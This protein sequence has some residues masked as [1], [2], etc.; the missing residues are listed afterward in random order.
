MS[1]LEHL[2]SAF[3]LAP[4]NYAMMYTEKDALPVDFALSRYG[5]CAHSTHEMA[6]ASAA[7]SALTAPRASLEQRRPSRA[8]R[9]RMS[10]SLSCPRASDVFEEDSAL[11]AR[12][13]ISSTPST[14]LSIAF[15][16]PV[17]GKDFLSIIDKV[18]L[19]SLTAS[20]INSILFSPVIT[21]IITVL[22][23]S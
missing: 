16:L 19:T 12:C 15:R 2:R 3:S 7:Q 8:R 20:I 17:M 6:S 5:E 10:G 4:P 1:H 14:R 23:R 22:E 13:G 18:N 21:I 9:S 11:A